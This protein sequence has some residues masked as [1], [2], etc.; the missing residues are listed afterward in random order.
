MAS[1]GY[2][3]RY[4]PIYKHPYDSASKTCHRF[5]VR[6]NHLVRAYNFHQAVPT[7]VYVERSCFHSA[8]NIGNNQ[9]ID[10]FRFQIVRFPN[11]LLYVPPP[12]QPSVKARKARD[13][14]L[15]RM[16]TETC[17]RKAMLRKWSVPPIH[18]YFFVGKV[19]IDHWIVFFAALLVPDKFL[20]V[21][22]YRKKKTPRVNEMH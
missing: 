7:W 19:M 4:S 3:R 15:E 20:L 11:V 8:G 6:V 13:L 5:Y 14:S 12:S 10:D 21:S 2:S 22:G 16:S 17:K 9:W 18:L 1:F